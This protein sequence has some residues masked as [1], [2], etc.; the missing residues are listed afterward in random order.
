MR[1]KLIYFVLAMSILFLSCLTLIPYVNAKESQQSQYEVSA[2]RLSDE[3]GGAYTSSNRAGADDRFIIEL[4]WRIATDY[5]GSGTHTFTLPDAISAEIGTGSLDNGTGTYSVN[6]SRE[7]T[8]EFGSGASGGQTGTITITAAFSENVL[9]LLS[10]D[11]LVLTFNDSEGTTLTI[12]FDIAATVSFDTQPASAE[13]VQAAIDAYYSAVEAAATDEEAAAIARPRWQY[14]VPDDLMPSGFVCEYVADDTDF[15]VPYYSFT[16]EVSLMSEGT[17]GG[18]GSATSPYLIEDALDLYQLAIN[19]NG[20]NRYTGFVF[21]L[22]GDID[23]SGYENWPGIGYSTSIYFAGSFNGNGHT[24][25]GLRGTGG[26]NYGLFGYVEGASINNVNLELGGALSGSSN[27]GAFVGCVGAKTEINDCSVEGKGKIVSGASRIGGFAGW[28][29]STSSAST[30][31][32]CSVI[33]IITNAT[34]NYA[35]GFAGVIYNAKI[36]YCKAS[37]IA[38]SSAIYTGGFAGVTH[39]NGNYKT[40]LTNC[41]A[42]GGTIT[43]RGY[44][45]GGF[46]GA[47]YEGSEYLNC[48]AQ[49]D[50]TTTSAG[51]ADMGGFAGYFY[52]TAKVTNCYST[53]SVTAKYSGNTFVGGFVGRIAGTASA[54]KCYSSGTVSAVGSSNVGAFAGS[55]V[56]SSTVTDCFYDTTT[57][58]YSGAVV[59]GNGSSTGITAMSTTTAIDFSTYNSGGALSSWGVQENTAGAANGIVDEDKP[60]YIDDDI[61]YPYLYYQY[62]EHTEDEVNYNMSALNYKDGSHVAQKRSDFYIEKDSLP[63]QA[64]SAGAVKAYFPYSGTSLYEINSSTATDIPGASYSAAQDTYWSLGSVSS[65]GIISFANV[66]KTVKTSSRQVWDANDESTYTYVGDTVT[67]YVAVYN[68]S[69]EADYTKVVIKDNLPPGVTF[70]ENSVILTAGNDFE[71]TTVSVPQGDSSTVPSYLFDD[72]DRILYVYLDDMERVSETNGTTYCIVSFDVKVEKDAASQFA[73][74]GSYTGDIQNDGVVTGNLA[75]SATDISGEVEISFDDENYDPV[76]DAYI[77]TL[78]KTDEDDN[79]LE[80]AEFTLYYWTGSSEPADADKLV[81]QS[82]TVTDAANE[83]W[84]LYDSALTSDSDGWVSDFQ[85]RK[86][87]GYYQLV[88]TSAPA[89]YLILTCQWRIS[90]SPNAASVTVSTISDTSA[91][92]QVEAADLVPAQDYNGDTYYQL[93]NTLKPGSITINK[94]DNNDTMLAEA[95]FILE[96]VEWDEVSQAWVKASESINISMKTDSG[97][98]LIFREL[99]PGTYRITE[100]DP[101]DG[102]AP[103]TEPIIA[104]IPYKVTYTKGQTPEPNYDAAMTVKYD[105][106]GGD[107]YYYDITFTVVDNILGEL[108]NA[109]RNFN[110]LLVLPLIGVV[111]IILGCIWYFKDKKIKKME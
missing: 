34:S 55:R 28:V 70:I 45:I 46:C 8:F 11:E 56:T 61:T 30:I 2:V 67:Y 105:D 99:P 90:A 36:T 52:D 111:I 12:P 26:S 6:S 110:W 103:L 107:Y 97:G 48:Y 73:A 49:V 37:N 54:I 42:E 104:E 88:E 84:L 102:Y 23:I 65:T 82:N 15:G 109:G 63:L 106:G 9:S 66:P 98:Q 1:L 101:P 74:D 19:V 57:T 59:G 7:V 20:G 3:Q 81:T 32:N 21:E 89:G 108:P 44:A 79:P 68:Y 25:S 39:G 31:T 43:G 51:E 85:L 69:T 22:S 64:K 96:Q 77:L 58:R 29:Y 47:P 10:G 13:D 18:S 41:F 17:W 83:G 38:A 78:L 80:G 4:D 95:E 16:V 71:K 5:N 50:V 91:L 87:P 93:E 72:S 14:Q 94:Q 62:D 76:Y 60:W 100:V 86:Y 40:Y 75:Y 53:G 24:I 33:D 92:K 27:V 35:A